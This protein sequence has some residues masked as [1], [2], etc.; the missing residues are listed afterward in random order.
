[1]SMAGGAPLTRRDLLAVSSIVI[2]AP[3][4][5]QQ[6][7]RSMQTTTTTGSRPL[8]RLMN[9]LRCIPYHVEVPIDQSR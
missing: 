5:R 7:E 4:R 8:Y 9:R 1:M 3:P 6:D 2:R